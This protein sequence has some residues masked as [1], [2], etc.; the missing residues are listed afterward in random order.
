MKGVEEAINQGFDEIHLVYDY[1]GVRYWADGSW[2]RDNKK[3][4]KEY[5]RFFQ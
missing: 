1:I 2:K 3:Y 4:K 5:I